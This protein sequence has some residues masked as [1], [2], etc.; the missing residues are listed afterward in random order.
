MKLVQKRSRKTGLP[1]GTL[2]HIGERKSDTVTLTVFHSS[3]ESC[4]ELQ[5]RQVNQLSPPADESVIWINVGGVHQV[6][7]VETLGK[8]RLHLDAVAFAQPRGSQTHEE[9]I[10]PVGLRRHQASVLRLD[11]ARATRTSTA[12]RSVSALNTRR[13]ARVMR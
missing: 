4:E 6:D 7:I 13:P 11:R 8:E 3:G 10:R 5:P 1:P 2:V 12:R 9:A